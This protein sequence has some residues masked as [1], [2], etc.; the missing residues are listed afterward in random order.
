M[1]LRQ[2]TMDDGPGIRNVTRRALRASYDFLDDDVLEYAVDQWYDQESLERLIT[3][4]NDVILVVTIDDEVVAF[5]QS[6]ILGETES[7]GEIRWILT[8]PDYRHRGIASELFTRTEEVLRKQGVKRIRALVL[9]D[10]VDGV[11]FY[12]E[13][14]LERAGERTVEIGGENHT[15]LVYQSGDYDAVDETADIERRE[16]DGTTVFVFRTEGE[17]GSNAR[18]HPAYRDS[19]KEHL[20]AWFCAGCGSFDNAMD[21]MG[22]ME[23]NVCGNVRKPTRWDA[24][25]L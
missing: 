13:Q 5:S 14:G 19:D 25:Y 22:Q 21:S 11:G 23:C 2:A 3:E 7:T 16:V 1:D 6:A 4:D 10:N 24:G 8:D 9:A 18:F 15:E 12:E 17:R 20:Y